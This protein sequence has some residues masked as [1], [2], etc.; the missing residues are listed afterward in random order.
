MKVLIEIKD[1]ERFVKYLIEQDEQY[2]AM[3]EEAAD[4]A[5]I[6]TLVNFRSIILANCSLTIEI[7]K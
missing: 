5:V 4:H 7:E 3:G 1:L 6:N 2:I